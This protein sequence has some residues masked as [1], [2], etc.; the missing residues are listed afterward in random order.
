MHISRDIRKKSNSTST[1]LLDKLR[2]YGFSD[3]FST[4]PGIL[5]D[6]ICARLISTKAFSLNLILEFLAGLGVKKI[7]PIALRE[8][9]LRVVDLAAISHEIKNL[10]DVGI[11]VE[12]NAF[13][14]AV[15]HFVKQRK[16]E[17]LWNML[18]SDLHPDAYDDIETQHRLLLWYLKKRMWMEANR[19]LEILALD[20]SQ[21]KGFIWN[22]LLKYFIRS[23]AKWRWIKY[24]D[25][26]KI[27]YIPVNNASV[28]CLFNHR[29]ALRQVGRN[30]SSHS[31]GP[32]DNI[33]SYAN[34][35]IE[36]LNGGESVPIGTWREIIKRLGMAGQM[37]ELAFLLIRL[38]RT[39]LSGQT[40]LDN[41]AFVRLKASLAKNGANSSSA[42][43]MGVSA[44][45]SIAFR[46][47]FNEPLIDAILSWGFING[48]KNYG[49]EYSK[50]LLQSPRA[51]SAVKINERSERTKGTG[52]RTASCS[53]TDLHLR[54]VPAW[55]KAIQLI[56]Q[57]Q[58]LGIPVNS[59]VVVKSVRHRIW[60]LYGPAVSTRPRNREMKR[61][62]CF[63]LMQTIALINKAW[64]SPLLDFAVD[65]QLRRKEPL[66]SKATDIVESVKNFP[67]EEFN[68]D[69]S[70]GIQEQS[71]SSIS[72]RERFLVYVFG[73]KRYISKSEKRRVLIREWARLLEE[74]K[75]TAWI[76][77]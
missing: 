51:S 74:S 50:I 37:D 63:T 27:Y 1:L 8:L 57:L 39:Y 30:T 34:L 58:Q 55:A 24:M 49:D 35:C 53:E 75:D 22:T 48:G 38:A 62:H 76:G 19:T 3:Y 77:L 44:E 72:R 68:R 64:G 25:K 9:A 15:R 5:D 67:S 4:R 42:I 40:Y 7:G 73:E 66:A 16:A 60:T 18:H 29:L 20:G 36:V 56:S 47:M 11:A 52:D 45:M 46:N 10:E 12:D 2:S 31:S 6:K 26:M 23:S 61:L 65:D 69:S 14:K 54:N 28:K 59:N 21:A 70:I 41:V 33:S 71:S 17:V 13:S 32:Y 43:N